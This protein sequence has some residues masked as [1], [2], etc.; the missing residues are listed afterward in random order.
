[1]DT[2]EYLSLRERERRRRRQRER[3]REAETE[4][5]RDRQRERKSVTDSDRHG[6][7]GKKIRGKNVIRKENTEFQSKGTIP[8]LDFRISFASAPE[9]LLGL[10]CKCEKVSTCRK[11]GKG[12]PSR[13]EQK[14]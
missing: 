7:E 5:D 12:A 1:M 6:I 14:V 11:T 3:N 9:L 4:T 2:P 13:W 8:G 10:L